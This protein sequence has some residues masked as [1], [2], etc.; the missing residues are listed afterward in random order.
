MIKI[1]TIPTNLKVLFHRSDAFD[2][3]D[4]VLNIEE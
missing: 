1:A 3:L 4:P 2:L